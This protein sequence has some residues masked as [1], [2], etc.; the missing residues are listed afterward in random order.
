MAFRESNR[1]FGGLVL[2]LSALALT[3]AGCSIAVKGGVHSFHSSE[4]E[5]LRDTATLSVWELE[6]G[7]YEFAGQRAD[8]AV[9]VDLPEG[10]E[11]TDFQDFR[12]SGRYHFRHDRRWSPYV[13]GGAGWYRWFTKDSFTI[14]PEFCDWVISPEECTVLE[15]VELSSG[16]YPHLT[17][18]LNVGLGK[19]VD[20]VFEGRYDFAK[21]DG[22][23][24]FSSSQL[25]LGIRG[26]F[27]NE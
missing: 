23:Y 13:G 17:A 1:R 11:G 12:V 21:R 10:P 7:V 19:S 18:G 2:L 25:V 14:P 5:D 20:F 3:A 26:R 4:I 8:L 9:A 27:K 24:D 15:S 6:F 22:E 16:F